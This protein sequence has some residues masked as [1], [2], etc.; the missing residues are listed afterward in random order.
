MIISF[1][2]LKKKFVSSIGFI[3]KEIKEFYRIIIIID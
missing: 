3:K 2:F 1:I